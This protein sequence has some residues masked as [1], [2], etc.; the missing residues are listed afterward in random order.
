M[1]EIDSFIVRKEWLDNISGLTLDQQD[2]VIAEIVRY[3]VGLEGEYNNDPVIT[4]LVNMVKGRIDFSKVKYQEKVEMSKKAGR[5]RKVDDQQIYNLARSGKSSAEI[6]EILECS[7][8]SIDH[9]DGWKNR[10]NED[11]S[12]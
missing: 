7:K 12:F 4:S 8:S 9:S 5:K 11:F 3:G 6:A 2:K 1:S 10:K